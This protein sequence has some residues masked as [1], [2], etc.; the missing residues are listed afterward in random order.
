MYV[1]GGIGTLVGFWD[2]D[3]FFDFDKLEKV[4]RFALRH[5][6]NNWTLSEEELYQ[7][8]G[9]STLSHRRMRLKLIQLFKFY[10]KIHN[11]P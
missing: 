8:T 10:R 3:I 4:Q 5:Y 11:Y 1:G 9:W 2:F 6:L 7:L